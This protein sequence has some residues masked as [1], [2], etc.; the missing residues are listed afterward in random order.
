M[1]DKLRT[2]LDELEAKIAEARADGHLDDTEREELRV[3]LE[4]VRSDLGT[5]EA[6]REGL[7]EQLEES[8]VRFES[9]HPTVAAVIRSAVH[10]LTGYGI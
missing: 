1:D 7:A 10:T 8:A 2:H 4:Q 5:G 6:D 3:L 9:D